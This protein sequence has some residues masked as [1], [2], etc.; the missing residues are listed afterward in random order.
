MFFAYFRHAA[1]TLIYFAYITIILHKISPMLLYF[2]T[3]ITL[4]RCHALPAFIFRCV[5][6]DAYYADL[7]S[8]HFT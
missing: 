6:A 3:L 7:F 1:V 2:A 8:R 4:F 5:Y